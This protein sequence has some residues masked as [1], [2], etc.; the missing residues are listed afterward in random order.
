M[1]PIMYFQAQK[2]STPSNLSTSLVLEDILTW[3]WENDQKMK[4][5]KKWFWTYQEMRWAE[6]SRLELSDF[7]NFKF[8][9]LKLDLR[10]SRLVL[11]VLVL[12]FW[13]QSKLGFDFSKALATEKVCSSCQRVH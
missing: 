5:L 13:Y 10:K 6:A 12:V 3:I 4:V 11:L 7:K 2:F 1:S 8:Y 9:S